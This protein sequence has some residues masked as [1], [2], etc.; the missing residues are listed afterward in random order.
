MHKKSTDI[1][2]YLA[3][4]RVVIRLPVLTLHFR[5]PYFS[6]SLIPW[7]T[8]T[9]RS[10]LRRAGTQW[11]TTPWHAIFR[12]LKQFISSES[13]AK[14]GFE[15][16]TAAARKATCPKMASAEKTAARRMPKRVTTLDGGA[17]IEAP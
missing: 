5:L 17:G 16:S 12:E 8:K 11:N 1:V 13:S 4:L 6:P 3:D 15:P 7:K 2:A 14:H 10:F 9:S